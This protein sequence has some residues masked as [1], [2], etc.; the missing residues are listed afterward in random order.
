MANHPHPNPP[1]KRERG[2]A[3][4]PSQGE[5]WGEGQ[6]PNTSIFKPMLLLV[7]LLVLAGCG[8]EDAPVATP[9]AF[10]PT[11]TLP[12]TPTLV[13]GALSS[14]P[15]PPVTPKAEETIAVMPTE[16]A[17][18]NVTPT[19]TPQPKERLEIGDAALAEENVAAAIEQNPRHEVRKPLHNELHIESHI[20][21]IWCLPQGNLPPGNSL[22]AVDDSRRPCIDHLRSGSVT[23]VQQPHRRRCA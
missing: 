17:V 21:Y 12:A 8:G 20:R 15:T 3:P 1:P 16:T 5:G 23:P 10:Q 13:N 6:R 14:V 11:A 18:A 7:L 22:P 19:V 4:S 2:L 9:I